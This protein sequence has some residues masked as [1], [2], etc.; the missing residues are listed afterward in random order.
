MRSLLYLCIP[1]K[2]E[3]EHMLAAPGS[4]GYS[5]LPMQKQRK[6]YTH[7]DVLHSCEYTAFVNKDGITKIRIE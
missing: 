5:G 1:I 3:Q 6:E 2:P 7:G 4:G